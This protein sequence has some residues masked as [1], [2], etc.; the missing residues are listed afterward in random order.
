MGEVKFFWVSIFVL[1]ASEVYKG[2]TG[3]TFYAGLI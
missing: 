2:G 3:F 1:G